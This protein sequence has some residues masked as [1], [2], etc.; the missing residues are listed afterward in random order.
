MNKKKL[1]MV[2]F[3]F[4][5]YCIL[6]VII[7]ANYKNKE[8]IPE[9]GNAV[10]KAE[11]TDIQKTE[12]IENREDQ[13]NTNIIKQRNTVTDIDLLSSDI[14]AAASI[15]GKAEADTP[16]KKNIELLGADYPEQG[17]FMM[18][19]TAIIYTIQVPEEAKLIMKAK[20]YDSIAEA[21]ISDGVTIVVEVIQDGRSL[22]TYEPIVISGDGKEELCKLDFAEWQGRTVQIKLRCYDGGKDNAMGDWAVIKMLQIK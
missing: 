22:I 20:I 13:S 14:Y 11:Q 6:L 3:A 2:L 4:A 16:W 21:G 9:N 8:V 10:E 19:G 17:L 7:S 15:E 5:A 12:E 18:P 1:C